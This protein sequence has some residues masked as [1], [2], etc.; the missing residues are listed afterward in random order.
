MN[1][2]H[3]YIHEGKHFLGG[4][5][6]PLWKARTLSDVFDRSLGIVD[7]VQEMQG[8]DFTPWVR[9]TWT[10]HPKKVTAWITRKPAFPMKKKRYLWRGAWEVEMIQLRVLCLVFSLGSFFFGFWR[11]KTGKRVPPSYK[12]IDY[13][14][15][16]V[17]QGVGSRP[18]IDWHFEKQILTEPRIFKLKV[19]VCQ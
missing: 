17:N 19:I 3:V 7:Q 18:Q 4:L 9:V 6:D 8:R 13:S 11:P 16:N 5:N 10:H 2:S 15:P 14:Y 12:G 1:F